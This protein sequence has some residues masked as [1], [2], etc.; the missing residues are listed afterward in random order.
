MQAPCLTQGRAARFDFSLEY[1]ALC[2]EVTGQKIDI[3]SV[4]ETRQLDVPYY[5]TD[6]AKTTHTFGWHPQKTPRTIVDD[7]YACLA[8]NHDLVST[9]FT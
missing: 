9:V 2:E 3:G 4:S 6:S 5:V 8:K 7:I 1:T